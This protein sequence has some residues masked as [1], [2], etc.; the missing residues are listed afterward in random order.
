[1]TFQAAED[2]DNIKEIFEALDVEAMQCFSN[3]MLHN[4]DQ[5][6]KFV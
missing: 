4:D 2:P 3:F 6:T 1:M 5:K